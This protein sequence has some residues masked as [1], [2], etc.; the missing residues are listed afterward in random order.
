MIADEFMQSDCIQLIG[1]DYNIQIS[2]GAILTTLIY[3]KRIKRKETREI[4][5]D[6][7]TAYSVPARQQGT[8]QRGQGN[9]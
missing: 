2:I 6:M 1:Q 5:H 9:R 7:A 4:T 3:G 8:G